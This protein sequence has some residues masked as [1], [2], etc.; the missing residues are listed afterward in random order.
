VQT[1]NSDMIQ[2][3]KATTSTFSAEY[4]KG[5]AVLN[6]T[7]KAGGL[8][9]T[10]MHT[11]MSAIR[12][13]T[14]MTGTTT[15]F[16][17]PGLRDVIFIQAGSWGPGMDSH[18]RFGPHNEKLF[19]F[20]G[21]EYYNQNFWA[22][23]LGSWVP[24]MSERNGDFS[25]E[26]LNAQ[27]CGARPD[28]GVNLNAVLPMCETNNYLPNGNSIANGNVSP[29]ANSSGV[30]LVNWLPLPNADPFINEQGY[31]YVQPVI[32][33]QNGYQLHI[34]MDYNLNDSN[35]LYATWGR[36][37]QV[38]DEPVAWDTLPTMPW[39]IPGK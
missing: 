18:T 1:V 11:C 35:K 39:N 10:V 21:Y 2:E 36:Q 23:T 19:F 7:T 9:T 5:P 12:C 38:S 14:P 13:S 22:E 29:Y 33:T 6:A 17:R 3:I 30:A 34:R 28:G 27:L 31:N 15:I 20:A 4:A 25:A 24:T 32:Q 26:S 37:Q 8:R 16:S